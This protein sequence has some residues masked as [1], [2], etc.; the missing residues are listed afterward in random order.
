MALTLKILALT[1]L[2]TWFSLFSTGWLLRLLLSRLKPSSM[3]AK[4][5]TLSMFTAGMLGFATGI[6]VSW[7]VV[8]GRLVMETPYYTV[9]MYEL[10][11]TVM[12]LGI[13]GFLYSVILLLRLWLRG[14]GKAFFR[15]D[16]GISE[17]Y[18]G[19]TVYHTGQTAAPSLRGI[20]TPV[21][22]FPQGLA[23]RLPREDMELMLEHEL[24]HHRCAHNLKMVILEALGTLALNLGGIAKLTTRYRLSAEM[25]VDAEMLAV[26][27]PSRYVSCLL[28][29][30]SVDCANGTL[31]EHTLVRLQTVMDRKSG[32]NT[33]LGLVLPL[34]VAILPT[35]VVLSLLVVQ[36]FRCFFPCFLGY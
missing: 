3:D 33:M 5:I 9:L 12:F 4:A 25:V 22:L 19:I 7:A 27:E 26:A 36:A 23:A 29:C 28:Q 34:V 11:R 32:A 35:A 31:D 14:R 15:N 24:L 17:V 21:V 20:W 8:T 18:K 6:G 13:A 1:Y 2:L 16:A 30:E 10:S